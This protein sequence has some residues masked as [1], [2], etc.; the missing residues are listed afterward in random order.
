[1][2]YAYEPIDTYG[3]VS[4]M[5]VRALFQLHRH[6]PATYSQSQLSKVAGQTQTLLY[7][8][9]AHQRKAEDSSVFWDRAEKKFAAA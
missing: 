3:T 1:M 6:N 7:S 2:Q 9:P 5:Y 4:S 8:S